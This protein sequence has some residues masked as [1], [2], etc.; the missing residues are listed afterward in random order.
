[1]VWKDVRARSSQ[2]AEEH[3]SQNYFLELALNWIS[4]QHYTLSTSPVFF[5]LYLLKE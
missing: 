5:A 1:V 2:Q 3:C 4:Q